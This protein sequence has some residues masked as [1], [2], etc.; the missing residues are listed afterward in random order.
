MLTFHLQQFTT[1]GQKM[2]LLRLLIKLLSNRSDCLDHVLTAIKNDEKLSGTNKVDEFKA[3]IFRSE[4]KS[5]R[6]CDGARN[7]ARIGQT[8]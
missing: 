2:D 5:Q 4:F 7:V 1:R 3:G 6:R 8:L